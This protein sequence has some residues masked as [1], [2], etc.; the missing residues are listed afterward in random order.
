MR[1]LDRVRA[2]KQCSSRPIEAA[3]WPHRK[4]AQRFCAWSGAHEDDSIDC[5]ARPKRQT[6]RVRCPLPRVEKAPTLRRTEETGAASS[7]FLAA[8]KNESCSDVR[9]ED[10]CTCVQSAV[11]GGKAGG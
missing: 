2:L 7:A 5:Q 3:V 10:A 8:R 1:G 4:P 9:N 6:N 11:E